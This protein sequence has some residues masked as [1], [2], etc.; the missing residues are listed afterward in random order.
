MNATLEKASARPVIR[1]GMIWIPDGTFLMGSDRHYPEEH[2]ST[3][4]RR[5]LLDRPDAR[6]QP[7][8]RAVRDDKRVT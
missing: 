5:W 8:L 3:V 2:R 1:E 7:R 6:H 4:C